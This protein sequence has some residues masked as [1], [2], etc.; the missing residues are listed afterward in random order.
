MVGKVDRGSGA[1]G[2]WVNAASPASSSAAAS[3]D[4]AIGRRMNGAEMFTASPADPRRARAGDRLAAGG[5]PRAD[6][7]HPARRAAPCTG[8]S[9]ASC[10]AS[11]AA[12]PA[13]RRRSR[14]RA[15][16]AARSRSRCPS[17]S[18]SPPSSAAIVVIMMG[19][20]RSRQASWIASRGDQVPVAL[21]LEREV[22]HHDGVLLDDA[23]QQDDADE[24][25][26][27]Q[28][29]AGTAAAPAA[30]RRRPTAAS[31]GS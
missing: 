3:S 8:R 20:K 17:A 11:A 21:G 7:L 10:T 12:T 31:T 4:V 13:G 15:A 30:R 25:D 9:P 2:S 1:T 14:C 19:R 23:D 22:D 26:H 5:A 29:R 16:G 6:A 28:L 24:R 18:G 27:R